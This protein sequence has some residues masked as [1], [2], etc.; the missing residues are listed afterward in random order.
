[1]HFLD[2]TFDSPFE[3]LAFDE[4]LL[5]NAEQGN[6]G[7]CLRLWEIRYPTVVLGSGC[8]FDEDVE[9]KNCH[10]DSIPILRRSSGGGTV[11]LGK[12]CLLFS[13]FLR[14]D[15]RPGLASI[16]SSYV[17]IMEQIAKCLELQEIKHDGTSDLAWNNKKFSGN[18]QQRKSTFILHH[19]SILFDFPIELIPRYLKQPLR[20]PDYRQGRPHD[21][22][23]TNI[24]LSRDEIVI[25][26]KESWKATQPLNDLPIEAMQQLVAEKYQ[27]GSWIRRR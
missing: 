13:L 20:Q 11:L 4:A 3:N 5:L 23:V 21:Q 15:T 14:T 22:F 12:G 16:K 9:E 10:L 2:I 17:S 26:L 25:K 8:K 19:G 24:P 7:E 6:M 18:A 1:M 27:L